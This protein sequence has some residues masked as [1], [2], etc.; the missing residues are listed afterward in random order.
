M[1]YFKL[2]ENNNIIIEYSK[3]E[4]IAKSLLFIL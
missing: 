2:D 4:E 3:E 1:D